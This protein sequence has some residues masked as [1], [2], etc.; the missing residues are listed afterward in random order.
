MQKI[1]YRPTIK[2]TYAGLL[3]LLNDAD[4]QIKKWKPHKGMARL[5]YF[6][7]LRKGAVIRLKILE[8]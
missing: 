4:I 7:A 6:E 8:N 5:R 3:I 2:D 1:T